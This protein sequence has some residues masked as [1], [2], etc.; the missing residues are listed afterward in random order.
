MRNWF[1]NIDY[2]FTKL[3]LTGRVYCKFKFC[4]DEPEN[5]LD[6]LI[7]IVGERPHYW[8]LCFKCPCGCNEVIRLNILKEANPRWKFSIRWR[9]ITIYPSIWRKVG[10]KSHFHIRKGKVQWSFM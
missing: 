3:R 7:Y 1:N 10:C 9:Q 4:A 8:M 6:K 5:I 2:Y